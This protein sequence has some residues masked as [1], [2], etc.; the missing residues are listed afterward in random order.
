MPLIFSG[1][2][3]NLDAFCRKTG[4]VWQAPVLVLS[5][6]LLAALLACG[7]DSPAPGG[8]TESA[9]TAPDFAFTLLRGSEALGATDLNFSDL[10]GKPVVLNFWAGLCPPCRAEMPDLQ[11][12]HDERK[13]E[14]TLLGVDIGQFM[15]LGT[16]EDA[17]A[18]LHDLDITYPAG[19][20]NDET[21]VQGFKVLGMP[22][23]VFINPDGSIFNKWTG[24]LNRETLDEQVDK[25]MEQQK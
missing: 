19:F 15:G 9:D 17:E 3:G 4:R 16:L 18:L 14:V 24:A 2:N 25:L 7:G 12:F 23:T 11:E 5:I 10:Q 6:F 22:T 21:V 8:G 20:T 13:A 1:L